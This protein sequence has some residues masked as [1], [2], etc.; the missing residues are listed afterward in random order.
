ML[1]LQRRG[2]AAGGTYTN[3]K[4]ASTLDIEVFDTNPVLNDLSTQAGAH[5]LLSPYGTG[6]TGSV[7]ALS[8]GLYNGGVNQVRVGINTATPAYTLM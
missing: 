5:F 7:P 4:D 6:A 2:A 1:R 3:G 8:M